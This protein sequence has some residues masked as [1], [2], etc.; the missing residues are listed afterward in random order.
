MLPISMYQVLLTRLQFQLIIEDFLHQF[1]FSNFLQE[2]TILPPSRKIQKRYRT[3]P[4]GEET[5]YFARDPILH[6][7]SSLLAKLGYHT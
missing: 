3:V 6:L 4:R 1:S 2:T 5:K 7:S